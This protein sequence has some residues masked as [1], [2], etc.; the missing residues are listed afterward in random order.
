MISYC[1]HHIASA[2]ETMEIFKGS[3]CRICTR[4]ETRGDRIVK[5]TADKFATFQAVFGLKGS[6]PKFRSQNLSQPVLH[7]GKVVITETMLEI[8]T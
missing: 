4:P 5:S 1:N 3:E 7:R 8:L 2:R 6:P